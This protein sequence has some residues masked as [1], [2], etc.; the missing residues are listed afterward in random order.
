MPVENIE[1]TQGT[2]VL[3][4]TVLGNNF[5]KELPIKKF[6]SL[7]PLPLREGWKAYAKNLQGCWE[8]DWP[9]KRKA[10]VFSITILTA[11]LG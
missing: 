1:R 7:K 2:L 8:G 10:S 3:T 9:L 6:L 11:F 5:H 4:P